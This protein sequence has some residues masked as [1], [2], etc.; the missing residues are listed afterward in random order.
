MQAPL[1]ELL[2]KGVVVAHVGEHV[3]KAGEAPANVYAAAV[4]GF[5]HRWDRWNKR[6]GLETLTALVPPF[7]MT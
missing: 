4:R 5:M 1:E 7:F 3:L 6:A 2:A